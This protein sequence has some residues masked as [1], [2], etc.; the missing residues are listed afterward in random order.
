MAKSSKIS[1]SS[2]LLGGCQL[3]TF[4]QMN[5]IRIARVC[6]ERNKCKMCV[7]VVRYRPCVCVCATLINV[8][9][10]QIVKSVLHRMLVVR[11]RTLSQFGQIG[12]KQNAKEYQIKE[13]KNELN[14]IV[15]LW[16]W[17]SPITSAAIHIHIQAFFGSHRFEYE[18]NAIASIQYVRVRLYAN[19][20]N[21]GC[22]CKNEKK[23]WLSFQAERII[24]C[25]ILYK[26]RKTYPHYRSAFAAI[27]TEHKHITRAL[28]TR[29]AHACDD[30][31]Y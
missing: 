10:W 16:L 19:R 23:N 28:N 13:E 3:C 22:L 25:L 31:W 26:C 9:V 30:V 21:N 29:R 8:L 5:A 11:L 14:H 12:N 6:G 24:M 4:T 18:F 15:L 2:L 17:T 20:C 1:F 27:H 7:N